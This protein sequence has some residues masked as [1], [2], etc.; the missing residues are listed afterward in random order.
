MDSG[1]P[2]RPRVSRET[3]LLLTTACIAI[4][5]LWLLAR[6]RFADRPAP[7]N[8]VQP[9]L[10]RLAARPTFGDLAAEI[11][12]LRPQL[13]P[14]L[15]AFDPASSS[16]SAFPGAARDLRP[17]LRVRADTAV[18][19]LD[20]EGAGAADVREHVIGLDPA[21]WLAVVRVPAL[22]APP[23]VPWV[24]NEAPQPR[25]LIASDVSTAD[26]ALRPVFVGALVPAESPVWPNHVWVVPA[27]ADLV[28]GSFV[29]TI[30]G[31]LAGLVVEHGRERAILPGPA[32]LAEVER[33]SVPKVRTP[34]HLGIQVQS[35]TPPI[36]RATGASSGVVVTWVDAMGPSAGTVAAGDVL[37]TANGEALLTPLHWETRAARLA[38]GE[39]ISVRVHRGRE[40]REVVLVAVPPPI[41]PE[42]P[43]LG[44]ILRSIPGMGA[45]VTRVDPGSVG[46]RAGIRAGDVITRIAETDAPT[47]GEISR[48]FAASAKGQALLL[49]LTRDGTHRVTALEK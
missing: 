43:S 28:P 30:D 35:L 11:S 17:A 3:R 26:L 47:A 13:R 21:S 9:I 24:S 23:P 22:P 31:R 8:P 40:A 18:V 6:V 32:L 27:S 15:I 34:G 10:T 42:N 41:T 5:A 12:Q 2:H 48:A 49:V 36:A 1:Q 7:S 14:L 33:L 20:P 46:D 16:R 37:E 19:L 45:T 4:A 29:F 39:S 44:L 38:A 25:Y